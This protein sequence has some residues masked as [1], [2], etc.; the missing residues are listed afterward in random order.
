MECRSNLIEFEKKKNIELEKY[1][2]TVNLDCIKYMT[3][4]LQ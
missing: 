3:D 1:V 2:K 4:R